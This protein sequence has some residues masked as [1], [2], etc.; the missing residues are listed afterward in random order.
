MGMENGVEIK[1]ESRQWV[2]WRWA[3]E[4]KEER[5]KNWGDC[6]RITIKI[7]KILFR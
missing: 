4:E 5:R 1:C 6:Y 3:K 7:L 2:R